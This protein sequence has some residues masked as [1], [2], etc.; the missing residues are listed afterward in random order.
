MLLLLSLTHCPS[1]AADGDDVTTNTVS[2]F[3]T[4]KMIT[5]VLTAI[6]KIQDT[7]SDDYDGDVD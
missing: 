6:T 5:V 4:T 3:I 2:S 7:I 1:A